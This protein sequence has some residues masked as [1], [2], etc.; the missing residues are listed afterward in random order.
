[1]VLCCDIASQV[2]SS[3]VKSSQV[4]AFRAHRV[5]VRCASSKNASRARYFYCEYQSLRHLD[6]SSQ[7]IACRTHLVL[8]CLADMLLASVP[9]KNVTST[10]GT[11]PRSKS[12][13]LLFRKRLRMTDRFSIRFS[14]QGDDLARWCFCVLCLVTHCSK[15][16]HISLSD[17]YCSLDLIER[18]LSVQKKAI[19][20][21]LLQ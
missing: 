13:K 12:L 3:Q 10:A 2:K 5:L 17:A 16:S 18:A 7:V 15:F 1:M 9:Y 21:F 8:I 19:P 6:I 14:S 11:S 20:L 4:I